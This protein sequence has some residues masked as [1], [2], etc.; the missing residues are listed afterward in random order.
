M[1]KRIPK[2]GDWVRREDWGSGEFFEVARLEGNTLWLEHDNAEYNYSVDRDLSGDWVFRDP[3][4]KQIT[5]SLSVEAPMDFVVV[6]SKRYKKLTAD[7]AELKA[8]K[9]KLKEMSA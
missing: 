5:V 7:E 1:S 6:D 8:L 2:V 3:E 4:L 9:E